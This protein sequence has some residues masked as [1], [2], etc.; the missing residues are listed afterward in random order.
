MREQ[1]TICFKFIDVC[2]ITPAHAGT[3]LLQKVEK[4][5]R[6]DHPRSCGNNPSLM[7][8]GVKTKGSPPL[9]REQQSPRSQLTVQPGITPAHAGTTPPCA[10]QALFLPDHPRSCGNNCV[11]GVSFRPKVGSPP[12]MREQRGLPRFGRPTRWDHPRS[13]RNNAREYAGLSQT[14]GSPPLMREQRT[15]SGQS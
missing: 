3:T 10:H 5:R 14:E 12:L 4:P 8:S 1:P 15:I 11:G 9:M 2:R 13:C 6:G 7:F